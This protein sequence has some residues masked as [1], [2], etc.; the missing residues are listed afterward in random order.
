MKNLAVVCLLLIYASS[1]VGSLLIYFHRPVIHAISSYRQQRRLR[2]QKDVIKDTV[3]SRKDYLANLH[4]NGEI[5]LNGILHDIKNIR[6]TKEQVHLRVIEDKRE[7]KWLNSFSSILNAIQSQHSKKFPLQLWSWL[8]KVYPCDSG[9]CTLL[10]FTPK[11]DHVQESK[12][13]LPSGFLSCQGQ[14][15]ERS[16]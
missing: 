3:I 8:F 14:P 11:A 5:I 15:P 4:E 9:K 7:T 12:P 6:F 1:Q 10:A 2:E 16:A 13:Y